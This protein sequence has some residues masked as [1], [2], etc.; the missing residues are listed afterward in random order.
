[1]HGT[2]LIKLQRKIEGNIVWACSAAMFFLIK[3]PV[4]PLTFAT[5]QTKSN[6]CIF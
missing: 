6:I 5:I 4:A 3:S 2:M 1:M